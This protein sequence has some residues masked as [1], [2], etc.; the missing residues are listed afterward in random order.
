[1]KRIATIQDLSCVGRCSLTVA[2]PIISAAG[3]E[4]CGIPTAV[5][6]N[7][8]G[9]PEFY[10]HDL[11]EDLPKI[12]DRLKS[13]GITFDAIYTGYIANVSQM[14]LIEEFI[15]E[16]RR[17]NAPVFV[18]PV[19]GDGGGLYSQITDGY[20]ERM[21]RLCAKADVI[22]PNL[23]EAAFLLEEDYSENPSDGDVRKMLKKLHSLGTGAV[24]ITGIPREETGEIGFIAY[25]GEEFYEYFSEKRDLVCMGTGDIFASAMLAAMV[26]GKGFKR[27]LEIAAEFT[28][29]A[30]AR[31]ADDNE[32]RFYGVNFEQ[33]LPKLITMLEMD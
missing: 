20:A 12:S 7:H 9:F 26:R 32:R 29:E 30:V 27:S 18:D 4:C 3:V 15:E 28:T 16:F 11:T 25:D 33:A 23:T 8:T 21:R 6:S 2:L 31:T 1:M 19:M 24:V 10:K 22:T 14:E 17:E 13:L 5:L